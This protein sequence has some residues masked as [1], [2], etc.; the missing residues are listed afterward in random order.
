MTRDVHAIPRL[1]DI[2]SSEFA[3]QYEL[4]LTWALLGER[5]KTGPLDDSYLVYHLKT[6]AASGYFDGQHAADL[7]RIGFY[8][9]MIHGSVLCPQTGELVP[10]I[11]ALVV[12]HDKQIRRGYRAGRE[13][14]FNEAEPHERRP[15]DT[16]F[17][18]RLTES[19]TNMLSFGD[20]DATW[21]YS[22]GCVLGELSGQ[23]FPQ[24]QQEREHWAK[25]MQQA[26][27][28]LQSQQSIERD[29]EPLPLIEGTE[30][31]A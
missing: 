7:A 14:F 26:K 8:I 9:G 3:S 19:I 31:F 2:R 24:T 28:E 6:F 29:T 12:F 4:G 5:E 27:A 16:D 11:T 10:E 21:N 1:L 30:Q 20:S 17:L 15:T 25:A 18:A 22:I 23:L 13:W